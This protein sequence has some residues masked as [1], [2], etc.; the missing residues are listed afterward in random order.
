V[1]DLGIKFELPITTE[2]Q[3]NVF[4]QSAFGVII[5]NVHVCPTHSTPWEVFA[6]SYFAR[7]PVVVV[8]G[9]RGFAGKSHLMSVLGL[10]S[11]ITL[12]ADV[13]VLGGSGQ[14]SARVLE[15]MQS[16]WLRTPLKTMLEGEAARK[17]RLTNGAIITALAASQTSVRGPHIPRLLLDEVDEMDLGLLNASLGQPMSRNGVPAC[18][19]IGST[20]HNPDGT[21]TEILKQAAE[22]GWAVHEVCFRENLKPHGWLDPAEVER[23]R[24]TMPKAMF[25]TEVELQEP[26]P[27]GRAIDTEAVNWMFKREIGEHE[28]REGE[29]VELPIVAPFP[30]RFATGADWARKTDRTV[31][32]TLRMDVKPYRVMAF[33]TMNRRP[34]PY[35]IGQ[36]DE[37]VKKFPRK[38][39]HD[40]LGVGDVVSGFMKSRAEE[41]LMVGRARQDLFTNVVSAIERH[42]IEGPF[43]RSFFDDLRYV[44]NDDLYG[45]GHPPDSLVALAMAYHAARSSGYG[46]AVA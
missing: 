9:S 22:R 34:W 23:A 17:T 15:T 14:Q 7:A 41:V 36:F 35:M 19:T 24:L 42:E 33:Q 25:E 21:F 18:T 8:K 44:T 39:A 28:G 37:R 40:A 6:D 45:S 16:L 31:I 29:Y 3:L 46:F 5:P 30:G 11:A 2:R 1:S 26:S 43:I 13:N 12:G 32:V 27:E 20:H 10:T 4:V 38:A